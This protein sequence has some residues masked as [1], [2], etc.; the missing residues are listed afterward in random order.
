MTGKKNHLSLV[1]RWGR[2]MRGDLSD[3]TWTS[4]HYDSAFPPNKNIEGYKGT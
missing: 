3:L 1:L 4:M 2:K